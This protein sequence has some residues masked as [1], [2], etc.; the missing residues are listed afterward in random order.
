MKK[1]IVAM[2]LAGTLLNAATYTIQD[3]KN[4]MDA[5]AK[6][7]GKIQNGFF[8]NNFDEVA[9]GV[10]TL[11]DVIVRVKPPLEEEE[12]KDPMARYMNQKIKMTN[13][14]IKN[15]NQKSLTIL[16]RFKD[17]DSAQALQA[18]SKI[19]NQCMECHREVRKW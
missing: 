12:E 19:T 8:Y 14:I 13:K 1:M 4:D 9:E 6:A 10:T 15:I 18:Y 16:E 5:M 11:S 3:R 17:G 7:M 2:T